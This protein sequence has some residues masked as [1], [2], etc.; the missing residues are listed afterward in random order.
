MELFKKYFHVVT[1]FCVLIIYIFT[2]APSVVQI[3]SGE[4]AAV[5]AT[6]GIAHPTGYPLFTVAG[7]IFSLIPLPFTKIFQLNLLA[8]IYCSAGI[9]VFTYTAKLLLDNIEIT[10]RLK[11]KP[12][13]KVKKKKDR[14]LPANAGGEKLLIDENIKY[15]ISVCSGLILAFSTTYWLQSTSVEV[16][17]LHLLLISLVILF[18]VKAFMFNDKQTQVQILKLYVIYS[19]LLALSFS[20]HMTTIMIV[21]G[22]AVLF[23][24]KN[25][26]TVKSFKRILLMLA[27]FILVLIILYVYLPIRASQDPIFNWGNPTNFERLLRHI[28]GKQYQVWLFGSTSAAKQQLIHFIETLPT[29][30]SIGLLIALIGIISSFFYQRK[31]FIF[32]SISFSFTVLYAINYDIHDI[33]SYFLLAYVSLGF[34]SAFGF[35]ALYR[36]FKK[37]IFLPTIVAI[38]IIGIQF[39]SNFNM[40][41]QSDVYTYEDYTK[42]VLNSTTN[43]SIIFSYQWDFFISASY[44]FSSVD[45]FRK[46]VVV[47]DKELLRRS[48][49]YD[50][51]NNNY[52]YQLEN[53]QDEVERFKEALLPFERSEQFD[54]NLLENLYRRIMTDLVSNNIND[55]DFYISLEV[56]QNEMRRGEFKLPAGYNLV[57]DNLLFKV[58]RGDEYVP[59]ADPDFKIRIS[60]R[61]N[62]YID[63]I[64]NFVGSMLSTRAMY[65]LQRG[66][67]ERAIIYVRKMRNELPNYN[68]PLTLESIKTN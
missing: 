48:W 36:T 59:A 63:S 10:P 35:F 24:I 29:Q 66:R 6:L 65:E 23:F 19:A 40:V 43:G 27:I 50:Q 61:R 14:H 3:D 56:Y 46:D 20:N 15:V 18:T 31:V 64:E 30:F 34:F 17:S 16:Y 28:T 22:I 9:S 41:D 57:P 49:Y 13:K 11:S 45:E 39:F 68:L 5:Q 4:L 54:A 53:M 8:A 62:Y 67:I 37:N 2:V 51:L 32:L 7:Y 1:G 21:P 42:A 58:V 12:K 60:D 38:V 55:R 33:D 26:F 44:Y 47:V 52:P 25:K